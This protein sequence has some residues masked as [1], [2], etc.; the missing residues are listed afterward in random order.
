MNNSKHGTEGIHSPNRNISNCHPTI[1]VTIVIR[2]SESNSYFTVSNFFVEM[3][4][5]RPGLG[6]P[7]K[8]LSPAQTYCI[9]YTKQFSS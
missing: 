4:E 8:E 3:D 9:I 1:R 6:S 7:V 5:G 2:R